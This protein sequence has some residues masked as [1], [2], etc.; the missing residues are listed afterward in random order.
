MIIGSIKV[1]NGAVL[2]HRDSFILSNV[3]VVSVRKPYLAGTVLLC[4]GAIGFISTFADLLYPNE[5]MAV[6]AAVLMLLT[7]GFQVAQLTLLSRDLKG[8]ELSS[9]VWG[10]SG[11]LQRARADIVAERQLLLANE[12]ILHNRSVRHVRR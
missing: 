8:S 9:A 2:T 7:I 5:L 10:T 12:E 4:A 6:G 3:S 11:D 1:N